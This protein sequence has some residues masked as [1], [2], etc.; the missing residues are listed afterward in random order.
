MRH[1][2][3]A[4]VAFLFSFAG[5]SALALAACSGSIAFE[6]YPPTDVGEYVSRFGGL[7]GAISQARNDEKDTA[8]IVASGQSCGDCSS[9]LNSLRELIARLQSCKGSS[10]GASSTTA[11]DQNLSKTGPKIKRAAEAVAKSDKTLNPF[12]KKTKQTTSDDLDAINAEM[13]RLNCDANADNPRCIELQQQLQALSP[14][15]GDQSIQPSKAPPATQ[16]AKPA[17]EPANE[18]GSPIMSRQGAPCLEWRGVPESL[19]ESGYVYHVQAKNKCDIAIVASAGI[20]GSKGG[21]METIPAS[22]NGG[23]KWWEVLMSTGSSPSFSY[24]KCEQRKK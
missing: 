7:D 24:T 4:A 14:V 5:G 20:V 15:T 22:G 10:A 23:D 21:G 2:A 6:G 9:H 8:E 12:G 11:P 18:C 19:G 17:E 3:L 16:V 1:F 13:V